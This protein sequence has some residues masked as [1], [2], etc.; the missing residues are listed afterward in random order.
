MYKEIND[1]KYKKN[2]L[3]FFNFK[4]FTFNT[5]IEISIMLLEIL[6]YDVPFSDLFFKYY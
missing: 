2:K 6:N 5:V 4:Q 1:F 3:G